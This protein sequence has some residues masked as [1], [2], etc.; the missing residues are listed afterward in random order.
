M[1]SVTICISTCIVANIHNVIE[2]N[3]FTSY[4]CDMIISQHMF[5]NIFETNI[6]HLAYEPQKEVFLALYSIK[7]SFKYL[8]LFAISIII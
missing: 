7:S 3:C 6:Y 1:C 4:V 5:K 2:M 8:F